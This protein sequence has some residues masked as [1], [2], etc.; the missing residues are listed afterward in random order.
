MKL[1]IKAAVAAVTLFTAL[2]PIKADDALI[3][4]GLQ[5]IAN[6]YSIKK[7]GTAG[8]ELRFCAEDFAQGLELDRVSKITVTSLPPREDGILKLGALEVYSG[9]TIS[10]KNLAA[11]RFVPNRKGELETSFGFCVGESRFGV[12]YTCEV[13]ALGRINS[14]PVIAQP[15]AVTSGVFSG[16]TALGTIRAEDPDGDE[17]TLEIT[18]YPEHGTLELSDPKLGYYS[19]TPSSDHIGRDSFSVRAVDKYG[20]VSNTVKVSLTVDDVTSDE[21]FTDLNGHWANAAAI[22]C[23]R[24]GILEAGGISENDSCFYPDEPM[25]RAEFLELAMNAAGYR[26]F[27]TRNTGFADDSSIPEKYKGSVAMADML[28]II[29]GIET[30]SGLCFCPNNQITRAEAAV[31]VARLMGIETDDSIATL[32]TDQSVPAWAAPSMEA[33]RLD[34]IMRGASVNGQLSL[35]PYAVMTRAAAVQIAAEILD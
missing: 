5:V 35:A 13:F 29:S 33:L 17:L 22:K 12:E 26:D 7:T 11:L 27:S 14:P 25:S 32:S 9:Q 4:P 30:E 8:A 15:E 20:A 16:I 24:A 1:I 2:S 34:G 6:R 21:I 3:S 31:I 28:G 10:E 23:R 19:Y 18:A